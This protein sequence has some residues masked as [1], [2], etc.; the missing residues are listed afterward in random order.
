[1]K[2]KPQDPFS[3]FI[4]GLVLGSAIT[5]SSIGGWALFMSIYYH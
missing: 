1:M 5:A 3:W 2:L 4:I